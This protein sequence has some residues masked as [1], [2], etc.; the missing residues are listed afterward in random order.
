MHDTKHKLFHFTLVISNRLISDLSLRACAAAALKDVAAYFTKEHGQVAVSKRTTETVPPIKTQWWII[1]CVVFG[2]SFTIWVSL[3][4]HVKI[5]LLVIKHVSQLYN[6]SASLK[7]QCVRFTHCV[8]PSLALYGCVRNTWV[9][10][11]PGI[12]CYQHHQGQE[13]NHYQLCK[14]ERL[15]GEYK[16]DI[17]GNMLIRHSCY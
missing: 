2:A 7:V 10:S 16:F 12:W 3:R 4:L 14:G 13:G 8:V 15:Q 6:V 5:F 17:Q 1:Y 11:H 9:L